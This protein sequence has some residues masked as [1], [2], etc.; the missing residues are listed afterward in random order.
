MTFSYT[1]NQCE[2]AEGFSSSAVHE[3]SPQSKCTEWEVRPYGGLS[4]CLL[5]GGCGNEL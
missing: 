1:Q 5:T 4:V 2:S 3:K